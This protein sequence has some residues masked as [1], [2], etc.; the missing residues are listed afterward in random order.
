M[1]LFA[2]SD[3]EMFIATQEV[4]EK[5]LFEDDLRDQGWLLI[6]ILMLSQKLGKLRESWVTNLISRS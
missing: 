4:I 1:G 3:L 5:L 6:H 2:L